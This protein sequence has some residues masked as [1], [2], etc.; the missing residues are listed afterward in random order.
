MKRWATIPIFFLAA[1]LLAPLAAH[2]QGVTSAN[3]RGTV[4]DENDDP[5]PGVNVV[6]VHEPS[7]SQYGSSTDEDGQFTLANV[8]VGGPYTVTASFVGY[9]SK[10]ETNL[11]LD[12]GETRELLR[13]LP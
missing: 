1:L 3:I 7:G 10:Q 4:V 2:A 6:A 5:L 9:Q 11:Q 12:L 13:L 8:R